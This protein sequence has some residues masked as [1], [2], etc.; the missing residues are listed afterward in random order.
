MPSSPPR[1]IAV[2]LSL[3][4]EHGRGIL[5][6]IARFFRQQPEVTVLKFSDPPSY[7]AAVLRRLRVDGV[8]ARVATRRNEAVLASLGVPVVNVSGQIPT[9]RIRLINSDDLRVGQLAFDST[10]MS[11]P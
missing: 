11:P 8:I 4:T 5:R 7:D 6:G 3:S 10:S 2:Y 1:R 9:P